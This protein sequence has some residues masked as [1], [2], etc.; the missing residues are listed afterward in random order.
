MFFKEMFPIFV[1][2][3]K[4]RGECKGCHG[5]IFF[6]NFFLTDGYMGLTHVLEATA[7]F[8]ALST[9]WGSVGNGG[10]KLLWGPETFFSF[11]SKTDN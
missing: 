10:R 4:L 9:V 8:P 1:C 3:G 7:I 2:L 6:F 11:S 5:N